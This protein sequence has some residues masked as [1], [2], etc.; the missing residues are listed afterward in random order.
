MY[1]TVQKLNR[2]QA[3]G[4]EG[5]DFLSWTR[6]RGEGGGMD[7]GNFLHFSMFERPENGWGEK[8]ESGHFLFEIRITLFKPKIIS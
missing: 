4:G 5:G 1:S 3:G 6:G 7:G 2:L 8:M